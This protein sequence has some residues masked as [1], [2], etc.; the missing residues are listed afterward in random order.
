MKQT[1]LRYCLAA[2]LACLT[3]SLSGCSDPNIYGSIG[4]SSGYGGY[5]GGHGPH[6]RTS[7]SIGGRIR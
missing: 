1:L 2:A 3:A 5:Y 4:I 7:I 6:V